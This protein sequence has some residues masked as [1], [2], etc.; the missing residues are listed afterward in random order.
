MHDEQKI[1]D[2]DSYHEFIQC[3]PYVDDTHPNPPL[4]IFEPFSNPLECQSQ[5]APS[6]F[7]IHNDEGD[8][9][10]TI[11]TQETRKKFYLFEVHM[12]KSTKS[13]G[14]LVIVCNYCSKEFKWSKSGGYDTYRRHI[15]N[16]HLTEV[17]KSKANGQ[18]QIFRYAS[19]ND[20]LFHYF[21]AN[22][23]EELAR[24]VVVKHLPFNFDEKVG[25]VNYC[26]KA[27]NPSACRVSRIT[28]HMYTF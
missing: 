11:D 15:N 17:T 28:L 21:D 24:M 18:A 9:Q 7:E 12:K 1:F 4:I 8:D 14:S 25:F 10:E 5:N 22:N 16:T 13:D 2:T 6:H 20:Q 19:A 23:R 26:Q 3:Q 27:L